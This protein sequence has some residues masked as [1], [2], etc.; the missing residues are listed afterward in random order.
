MWH[1]QRLIDTFQ[2]GMQLCMGLASDRGFNEIGIVPHL[3]EATRLS[4]AWRNAIL[5]NPA[6]K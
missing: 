1:T 4:A 3:D 2:E 6:A 5:F